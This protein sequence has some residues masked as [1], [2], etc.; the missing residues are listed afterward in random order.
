[1]CD[2]FIQNN[3]YTETV[4][5]CLHS[6][7]FQKHV[8]SWRMTLD[9][10]RS[11]CLMCPLSTPAVYTLYKN[12]SWL[13]SPYAWKH[14]FVPLTGS[15]KYCQ[16]YLDRKNNNIWSVANQSLKDSFHFSNG[17]AFSN[18][19]QLIWILFLFFCCISMRLTWQLQRK[20]AGIWVSRWWVFDF[21]FTVI[22]WSQTCCYVTC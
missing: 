6:V 2:Q 7:Y 15:M 1:M 22:L 18:S 13:N 5:I 20:V 11:V 19:A 14:G 16:H 12:I 8:N 10:F 3:S 21:V 4:C 9:L 17:C